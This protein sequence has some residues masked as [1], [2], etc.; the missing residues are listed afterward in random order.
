[1]NTKKTSFNR[2][3]L[4]VIMVGLCGFSS[5]T[6]TPERSSNTTN[7]PTINDTVVTQNSLPDH[8][9]VEVI[10]SDSGANFDQPSHFQKG[11]IIQSVNPD[12]VQEIIAQNNVNPIQHILFNDS[13]IQAV[14]DLLYQSQKM[15]RVQQTAR[16]AESN[17]VDTLL[18][19]RE[20]NIEGSSFVFSSGTP[21]VVARQSAYRNVM[22]RLPELDGIVLSMEDAVLPPW[23]AYSLLQGDLK[24]PAERAKFV[25][26]M[27][28]QVVVDE[29]GK[30]LWV[31][32]PDSSSDTMFI[33]DALQAMELSEIGVITSSKQLAYSTPFLNKFDVHWLADI[34]GGDENKFH[35][36]PDEYISGLQNLNTDTLAGLT[37]N[38]G[39]EIR[40]VWD[41]VNGLNWYVFHHW[42]PGD[43]IHDTVW[44]DWI[45][46][47][48]GVPP[49]SDEGRAFRKV[50]EEGSGLSHLSEHSI[51]VKNTDSSNIPDQAQSYVERKW[52]QP[53]TQLLTDLAQEHYETLGWCSN[54]L[55]DVETVLRPVMRPKLYQDLTVRL[56]RLRWM[57]S[58]R[59]YA[60]QSQ[61]GYKL[62]KQ[63]R[64]E[65]EALYLESH[66]LSLEEM[67]NAREAMGLSEQKRNELSQLMSSIRSDFPQ[68]LIGATP[69]YWNKISGIR[70][71][72]VNADEIVIYWQTDFPSYARVF[73][74]NNPPV[75]DRMIEGDNRAV[76]YHQITVNGL[77]DSDDTVLKI[78]AVTS[79]GTVTNSRNIPLKLINFD[80]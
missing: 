58:L 46:Q 36:L 80:I 60:L 69:R 38:V 35:V 33:A 57:A 49:I 27:V 62:W 15:N 42:M 72:Q 70:I 7:Y 34:T 30:Q 74:S 64:V 78:Q 2:Y 65:Q 53:S 11:V 16:V 3:L 19:S 22:Q 6:S 24:S 10:P 40:P 68:V 13:G 31:Y 39:S 50:V 28:K 45:E 47:T 12:L 25:I 52:D 41:S 1:M 59:H 77:Q 32:L 21:L 55:Q 44:D 75:F 54:A 29:L 37:V 73:L 17:F 51:L 14:D 23:N 79:N 20:L 76:S 48:L 18:W 63:S 43:V 67:L 26:E 61:F 71:Q 56:E 66:L 8:N 9:P 5:C 4:F